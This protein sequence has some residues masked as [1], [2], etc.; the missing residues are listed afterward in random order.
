[1]CRSSTSRPT[2]ATATRGPPGWVSAPAKDALAAAWD[3]ARF[4]AT[5]LRIPMVNGE[6]DHFRRIE[7]YL[8]RILDSGPV[9]LPDGDRRPLR[10]VLP[11]IVAA[12]DPAG[13][14][15]PPAGR[16]RPGGAALP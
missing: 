4:P 5:R 8:W 7:S 2:R 9:P 14:L 1:M 6:R 13:Q 11:K 10:H 3:R 16:A 12:R 15:P